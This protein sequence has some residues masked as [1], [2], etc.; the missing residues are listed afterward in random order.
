MIPHNRLTYG[1]KEERAVQKVVRSGYW[2]GGKEVMKLE[3]KITTITNR[4]YAI[5]VSSGLS[6]LRLALLGLKVHKDDEVIVPAYSCVAIPNSVL[7]LVAIPVPVDVINDKWNINGN[8]I[9]SK[10]SPKTKA[11]IAVH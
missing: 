9:H 10:I 5:G 7:S 6:A 3:K 1:K 8:N 4:K 11:I 2:A